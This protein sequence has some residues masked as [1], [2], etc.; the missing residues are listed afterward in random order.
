MHATAL[1][2]H[3]RRIMKGGMRSF[4]HSCRPLSNDF[5][6]ARRFPSKQS[7]PPAP[8]PISREKLWSGRFTLDGSPPC[9]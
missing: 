2:I 4:C 9:R 8:R 5:S 7:T 3:E 6:N 1:K